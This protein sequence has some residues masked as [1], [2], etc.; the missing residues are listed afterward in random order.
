MKGAIDGMD[1][2]HGGLV[3]FFVCLLRILA[4][5]DPS[6]FFLRLAFFF[7]FSTKGRIARERGFLFF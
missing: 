1:T 2:V 4:L 6:K 7:F 3:M 5:K